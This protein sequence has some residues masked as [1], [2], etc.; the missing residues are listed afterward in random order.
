MT[1][2]NC[3][4]TIISI[5]IL[6]NPNRAKTRQLIM[7]PIITKE[8]V[9]LTGFNINS[10]CFLG[11]IKKKLELRHTTFPAVYHIA[12][13]LAPPNAIVNNWDKLNISINTPIINERTNPIIRVF[14]SNSG[15]RELFV[16]PPVI[17]E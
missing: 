4:Q 2:Q 16:I 17:W 7:Q 12:N 15:H 5:I 13:I 1:A 10:H 9:A 6:L 11:P 14:K 3:T 8:T